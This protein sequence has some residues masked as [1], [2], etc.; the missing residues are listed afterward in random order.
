[1]ESKAIP[2]VAIGLMV[3]M[4]RAAGPGGTDAAVDADVERTRVVAAEYTK[5]LPDFICTETIRRYIRFTLPKK[6]QSTDV[7]SVKLRYAG[8]TEDRELLQRNGHPAERPDEPFG[9]LDNMG[10]FGGMLESV[11]DR[12][13]QAEFRWESWKTVGGRQVGVFSYHVQ[14]EHSFYMLSFDPGGYMHRLVVAYHGTVEVDHETGGVL[15]LNYEAE[16]VPKDF[17]MQFAST[18]VDYGI[19]EVA[20]RKY[21]LPVRSEIETETDGLRSRN[22]TEFADYRRFS[23]DSTVRFGDTVE[24]Q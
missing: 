11:F 16:D 7:L 8:G 15:R 24:N 6:W 19:V 12:A 2:V 9:G 1:M 17:P 13:T 14:K 22:V 4:A 10:E 3:F 23:S 20:G 21:L 18:T 5:H